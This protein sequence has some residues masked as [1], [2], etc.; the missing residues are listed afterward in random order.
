MKKLLLSLMLLAALMDTAAAQTPLTGTWEG[1]LE[2]GQGHKLRIQFVIAT[3]PGGKYSVV[4]TTPDNDVIRNVRAEK[5]AFVDDKLSFEVTKLSGGFAGTLKRGVLEG[6]WAQE[7]QKLPLSLKPYEKPT[8]TKEDIE[9][10]R[11]EWTGSLKASGLAVTIV[12][13]FT[14]GPDGALRGVMDVPEQG[15]K[16][17]AGSDIRL[18]DGQFHFWVQL[19]QA[20]IDGTLKD[21]Q[22]VGQWYQMGNSSPLTLKKGKF[23]PQPKIL[24]VPAASRDALKGRWTGTLNGLAIAV[25]FE[26]DAQGRLYGLFDS[27][28]QNILNIP[29]TDGALAGTKLNFGVSGF[30][31]KFSGNLAGDKLAGEWS[32]MGLPKPLPLELK[33]EK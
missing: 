11:G 32:Q 28:Q 22:I 7:G 26:T 10:L 2:L 23:T 1:R 8:L 29:V 12:L 4:V 16:E 30:G 19:A 18:D 17:L 33:R 3:E 24:D 27:L 20:A 14:T 25:R 6:E 21:G 15:A 13:R 5:V 31:A 9:T